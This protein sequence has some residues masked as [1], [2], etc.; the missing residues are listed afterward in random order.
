MPYSNIS[1]T[2]A[3]ADAAAINTAIDTILEKMPFLISLTPKERKELYKM[4]PDAKSYID[5]TKNYTVSHP[6]LIPGFASVDEF[7]KDYILWNLLSPILARVRSLEMGIS[8]TM[9]GMGH[10]QMDFMTGYYSSAQEAAKRNVAGAGA[11]AA[12]LGEFFDRPD[13]PDAPDEPSGPDAPDA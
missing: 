10:E 6:S 4:G 2:L 9:M 13:Q 12:D 1:A 8:D 3:P 11:V 7:N 5:K